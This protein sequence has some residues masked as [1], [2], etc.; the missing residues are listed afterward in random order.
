MGWVFYS[1]PSK[2]LI[3][4]PLHQLR[5]GRVH[6]AENDRQRAMGTERTDRF[7]RF[8]LRPERLRLMT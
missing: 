1:S 8:G 7:D 5:P 4:D 6:H 3:P 2:M